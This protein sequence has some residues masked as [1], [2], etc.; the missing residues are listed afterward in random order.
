MRIELRPRLVQRHM[1]RAVR[2]VPATATG[3]EPILSFRNDIEVLVELYVVALP[4]IT[5]HAPHFVLIGLN[6]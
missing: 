2:A 3:L 1:G 6:V 5:D 4:V